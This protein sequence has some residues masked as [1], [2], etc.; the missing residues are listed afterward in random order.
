MIAAVD[1]GDVPIFGGGPRRYGASI[2]LD[3]T[4]AAPTKSIPEPLFISDLA[5]NH[6]GDV[7]H[8]PRIG[9]EFGVLAREFDFNF[10]FKPRYREFDAFIHPAF[11]DRADLKYIKHFSEARLVPCA[12]AQSHRGLW[13]LI[14]SM[15]STSACKEEPFP[16]SH[17]RCRATYWPPSS[18][19]P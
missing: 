16:C 14:L 7:E 6:I 5:N 13:G 18:P 2:M 3:K 8:G 11:K 9:A 10:A 17:P 4:T 1:S 12:S 15:P 19:S